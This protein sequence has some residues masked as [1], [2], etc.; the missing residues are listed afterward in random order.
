MMDIGLY[1]ICW[2]VNMHVCMYTE[3]VIRYISYINSSINHEAKRIS[4]KKQKNFT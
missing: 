3:H 1:Q 4:Y 2:A